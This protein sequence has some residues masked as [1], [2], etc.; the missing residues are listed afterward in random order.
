MNNIDVYWNPEAHDMHSRQYTYV[1]DGK[2]HKLLYQ[3]ILAQDIYFVCEKS[4]SAKLTLMVWMLEYLVAF[5]QLRW[6]HKDKVKK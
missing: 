1:T 6:S 4:G 3:V 2:Q 5:Q